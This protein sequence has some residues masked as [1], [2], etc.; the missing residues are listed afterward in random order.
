M[1]YFF[2]KCKETNHRELNHTSLS[3]K[4]NFIS[5]SESESNHRSL[6]SSSSVFSSMPLAYQSNS[7][8]SPTCFQPKQSTSD[9][10]KEKEESD[11]EDYFEDMVFNS[12]RVTAHRPA[13]KI[14][15]TDSASLGFGGQS[16][17]SSKY[18]SILHS[19]FYFFLI[20][21]FLVNFKQQ[22]SFK[23]EALTNTM[24]SLVNYLT[25]TT[26]ESFEISQSSY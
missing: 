1:I 21:N 12:S 18:V 5:Y 17:N 6:S 9:N 8:D 3:H 2:L 16:Y 22:N 13:I 15:L 14:K 20:L 24:D 10:E 25:P 4:S 26:F 23:N 11:K 19:D 7:I